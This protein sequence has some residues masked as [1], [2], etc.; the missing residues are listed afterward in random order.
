MSVTLSAPKR[1]RLLREVGMLWTEWAKD[2]D[3]AWCEQKRL[4]PRRCSC[5]VLNTQDDENCKGL[6]C[7]TQG[8][9]Y[10]VFRN[11]N[12]K[13][14][15]QN[16]GEDVIQSLGQSHSCSLLHYLS[17]ESLPHHLFCW[18]SGKNKTYYWSPSVYQLLCRNGNGK[19]GAGS[20]LPALSKCN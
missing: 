8:E 13:K 1:C 7:M 4:M 3:Q 19:E 12:L 2:K 16:R 6:D 10:F 18:C 17:L 15:L 5:S 20:D 11:G 14:L 9:I